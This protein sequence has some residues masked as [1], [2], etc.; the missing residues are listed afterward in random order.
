M[1]LE[2]RVLR[3]LRVGHDVLGAALAHG[4]PRIKYILLEVEFFSP[5]HRASLH[6][7]LLVRRPAGLRA[8]CFVWYLS[9]R[10][11]RWSRTAALT[12]G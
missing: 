11:R 10:W 8:H 4:S 9:R 12:S 6:H 2:R 3:A 5:T 1:A 7:L